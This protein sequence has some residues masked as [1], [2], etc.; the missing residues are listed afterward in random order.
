L[1]II[2][3]LML[4]WAFLVILK[5]IILNEPLQWRGTTYRFNRYE[6][7]LLDPVPSQ[8]DYS[9]KQIRPAEL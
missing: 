7:T 1:L 6:P 3:N 8:G 5:K 4:I 9:G 2:G